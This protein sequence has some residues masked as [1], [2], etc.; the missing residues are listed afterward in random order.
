MNRREELI[1]LSGQ[2]INGMMSADSST[3][4]KVLVGVGTL[5]KAVANIAVE[6]ADKML[7]KIDEITE[8]K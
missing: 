8:S 3:V 7:K 5:N 4:S 6:T 2:I 1:Q